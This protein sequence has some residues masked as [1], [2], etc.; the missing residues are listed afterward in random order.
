[1]DYSILLREIILDLLQ[2]TN[3]QFVVYELTGILQNLENNLYFNDEIE[4]IYNRLR[5]PL[6]LEFTKEAMGNY[7]VDN[8]IVYLDLIFYQN[9]SE[10]DF[11]KLSIWQDIVNSSE[12]LKEVCQRIY[13]T[14]NI[15]IPVINLN[16]T[17]LNG[18]TTYH[19]S[20]RWTPTQNQNQKEYSILT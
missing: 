1:M 15:I 20:Y 10:D 8:I 16:Y 2:H 5:N 18:N 9:F 7:V 6:D 3:V 4:V 19:Y 11:K 12:T 13:N 17:D 14:F